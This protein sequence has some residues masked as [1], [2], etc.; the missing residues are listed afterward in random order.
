ME[1]NFDALDIIAQ[2]RGKVE[3]DNIP[4][5]EKLFPLW[6]WLTAVFYL[7]EFILWQWLHQEWCLW[8]WVGIPLI[9][10]PAMVFIIRRDRE[11]ELEFLLT[12]CQLE[13]A[14]LDQLLA[15]AQGQSSPLLVSRILEQKRRL[16]PS[17][18]DKVFEL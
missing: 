16:V 10:I 3:M 13:P 8:L 14:H 7:L 4:T 2:T 1:E 15:C 5:G 9:G 17:G 18:A 12:G 6:G 11:E